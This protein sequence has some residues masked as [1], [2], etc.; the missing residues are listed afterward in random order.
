MGGI[1]G[2]LIASGVPVLDAQVVVEEFQIEI[3]M[4]QLVLDGLPNDPRHF[5]AVEF[6]D[7]IGYLDAVHVPGPSYRTAPIAVRASAA[8]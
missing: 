4:D 5:I 7:G 8:L 3:R 1:D 2:H 6:D